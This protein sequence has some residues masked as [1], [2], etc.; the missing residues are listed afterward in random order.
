MP[1]ELKRGG[2]LAFRPPPIDRSFERRIVVA[3]ILAATAFL[4]A[5]L[6]A[7]ALPA[8]DRRGVW[9]PLHLAL[10]G[11][12]STAIAAVMPF[13]VA[14]FAAVPPADPRLR[15]AALGLVAVGALTVVGGMEGGGAEMAALGGA[16]YVAGMGAAGLAM[17]R[18][19][20]GS[21][22]PSRG[23][24]TWAYVWAL[25]HV[26]VGATLATLLLAGWTPL[27]EIWAAGKPTHAW[28][29][30]V[31]FISLVIATT[32]L[33]FFPTV[34]G[35]RISA[36]RSARV[37]IAGVGGGAS[38]AA[39]GTLGGWDAVA[40]A[41]ALGLAAGSCGLMASALGTW[42]TRARWTTDRDW[43]LF[44]MGGLISA[45]AWFAAGA[46]ILAWRTVTMGA[47]PLAWSTAS[48]AGPLVIGWIGITLLAS[49]THLLPAVGPGSPAAHAAQRRLL[50]RGAAARLL[51][52]DL[53][54]L[55][56][57]IGLPLGLDDAA[58]L[59]AALTAVGVAGTALLLLAA[60]GV[61]LRQ[62]AV[63]SG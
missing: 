40:A 42:R 57:S 18:P 9:L 26:A 20:R 35:A 5:A 33:H 61:G 8:A 52:L 25:L 41:G 32:L 56:L 7:I 3:G 29:N 27:A 62:P 58:R 37:T 49:A 21:L 11:G 63:S 23:L 34:V 43:H 44:A 13:F 22:G 31:G 12:A 54:C 6:A 53:G 16:T 17:L 38:L 2:D 39:L 59:G 50:G 60:V 14:A 48:I 46:A 28:L 15:A 45:I 36:R 30:L 4:L 24:V 47:G 10:A 19:V 55:L 1:A 51:A